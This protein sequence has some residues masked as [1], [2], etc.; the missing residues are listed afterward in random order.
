MAPEGVRRQG[1]SDLV[2]GER[3]AGIGLL[4]VVDR[5]D[6]GLQPALDRSVALAQRTEA[7]ANHLSAA[8]MA[9]VGEMDALCSAVISW[10]LVAFGGAAGAAAAP[11]T[12]IA[13]ASAACTIQD[14]VFAIISIP[15]HF[16][17]AWGGMGVGWERAGYGRLSAS[18]A[19]CTPAA[20]CNKCSRNGMPMAIGGR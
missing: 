8:L 15:A 2:G 16:A 12:T 1:G 10:R 11:P 3:S 17:P 18:V 5:G 14:F 19:F 4:G 9:A 6:L 20:R 7:G 13:A